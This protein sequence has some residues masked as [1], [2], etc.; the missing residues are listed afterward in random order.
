MG[1]PFWCDCKLYVCAEDH[2]VEH[3]GLCTDFPCEQFINQYD[4]EHGQKSAFTRAGLLAYRTKAGTEKFC[5]A[6]KK[7]EEEHKT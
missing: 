2:K 5:E 1:H 6:V 3:C 4:P 7:L